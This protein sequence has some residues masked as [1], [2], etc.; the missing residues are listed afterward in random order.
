MVQTKK[1]SLIYIKGTTWNS[2][3]WPLLGTSNFG[4]RSYR[5]RSSGKA[6]IIKNQRGPSIT[7]V[8]YIRLNGQQKHRKL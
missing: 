5:E 6:S 8:I 4:R 7:K 1:A 3:I 2:E